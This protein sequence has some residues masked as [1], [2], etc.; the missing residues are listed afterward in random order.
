MNM[1]QTQHIS[2]LVVASLKLS[3]ALAPHRIERLSPQLRRAARFVVD[4]PG[5][6][7]TRSL[8]HVAQEADI[9]AP[10]FSRLA[11]A[12]GYDNYDALKDHC[13]ADL[14]SRRLEL[15]DAALSLKGI[16]V[17]TF[18]LPKHVAASVKGIE[19]L[20]RD[21]GPAELSEIARLLANARRVVLIGE[22]RARAFVDYATY[23]SDMSV[24]GWTV[25]GRG[26]VSLAAETRDLGSKDA[27]IVVTMKPYSRRSIETARFVADMGTPVIALTDSQL[28]PVAGLAKHLLVAS[29]NSPQFFP[30]YVITTLLI[31]TLVGMVVAEKGDD[32]QRRIA[33]N[34]LRSRELNEYWRD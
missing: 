20:L 3:D 31:E 32:A 25:I 19:T 9:P 16:E 7:A 8:R 29:A 24:D 15:P 18:T 11:R 23:L 33:E 14:L 12:I 1:E 5:E 13:R 27:A 17:E 21:I 30:S 26:T 4:N 2:E 22:M 10:T 34:T 6:V 28:S